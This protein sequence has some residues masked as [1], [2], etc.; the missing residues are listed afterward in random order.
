MTLKNK[1]KQSLKSYHSVIC[2]YVCMIIEAV[3]NV[4]EGVSCNEKAFEVKH[5]LETKLTL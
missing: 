4:I 3:R 5:L 2:M 1:D